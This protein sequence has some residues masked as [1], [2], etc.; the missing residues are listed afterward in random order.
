MPLTLTQAQI[1]CAKT[2]EHGHANKFKPLGVVVIDARAAVIACAVEDNSSIARFNI[3]RAKANASITFNTGTRG[4]ERIVKE[5]PHFFT[6]AVT[7]V[8]GGMVPVPGGVV[9]KD[10]SGAIIGAMGV[11][12]DTSDNDEA[13]ALAGVA[14]AGLIGDGGQ[15]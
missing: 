15:G 10:A 11:S 2:L 8:E 3:A 6:G 14:A 1:I 7:A 4:V 9:I 13:A 12:G 5:R